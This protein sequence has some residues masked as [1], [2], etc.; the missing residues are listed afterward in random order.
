MLDERPDRV[1]FEVSPSSVAAIAEAVLAIVDDDLHDLAVAHVDAELARR[2]SPRARWL[3]VTELADLLG[4]H[5]RTIYRALSSGRLVG[6][7][8]GAAW[9]VRREDLATWLGAQDE[10]KAPVPPP[11]RPAVNAA[12]SFRARVQTWE[13]RR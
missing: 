11:S 9:R 6:V 5:Q 4:V 8:V 13:T 2:D 10:R 12:A 1:A 7:R 3:T